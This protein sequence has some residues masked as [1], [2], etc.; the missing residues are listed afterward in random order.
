[1]HKI[2]S[3]IVNI[4]YALLIFNTTSFIYISYSFDT[5][6]MQLRL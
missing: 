5:F 3:L 6:F 4:D 1:M 2:Y